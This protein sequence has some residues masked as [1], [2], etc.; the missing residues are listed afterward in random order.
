MGSL[1]RAPSATDLRKRAQPANVHLQQMV[2]QRLFFQRACEERSHWFSGSQR[3]AQIHGVVAEETRPEPTIRC[4]THTI[5]R[6][7]VC[8]R[9]RSNHTDRSLPTRELVV[10]GRAIP[11][12]RASDVRQRSER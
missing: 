4:Q 1:R 9:H 2:L 7:A 8:V 5:A 10:L 6:A 11:A 3:V 12:R